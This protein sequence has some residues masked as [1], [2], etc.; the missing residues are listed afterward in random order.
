MTAKA[1]AAGFACLCLV[2]VF[3]GTQQGA[4]PWTNG[5][6]CYALDCI[7]GMGYG[8]PDCEGI[9]CISDDPGQYNDCLN[10][11]S[12]IFRCRHIATTLSCEGYC[13]NNPQK[14]CNIY[15][16]D[17]ETGIIP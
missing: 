15:W 7:D 6:Q 1:R 14:R 4:D 16:D 8:T 12:T 10:T 2:A 11:M 5:A 9:D 13:A 17:C 3:I